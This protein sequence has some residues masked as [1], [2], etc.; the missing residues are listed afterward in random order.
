MSN[1]NDPQHHTRRLA[2]TNDYGVSLIASLPGPE[3]LY[4]CWH[5]RLSTRDALYLAAW[6]VAVA[7]PDQDSFPQVLRDVL[8]EGL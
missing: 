8:A 2:P 1:E 6:L 4:L 5:K 3:Q 7:D